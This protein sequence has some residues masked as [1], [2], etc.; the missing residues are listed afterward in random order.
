MNYFTYN[1]FGIL[2]YEEVSKDGMLSWPEL[3]VYQNGKKA[4]A[5]YTA[6]STQASLEAIISRVGGYFANFF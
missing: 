6:V 4:S 3:F 5:L 1:P 2:K